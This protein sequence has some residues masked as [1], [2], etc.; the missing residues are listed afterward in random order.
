[1]T[2]RDFA[3]WLKGFFEISKSDELTKE[4]VQEIKTHLAASFV[5]FARAEFIPNN[6]I[7]LCHDGVFL[8]DIKPFTFEGIVQSSSHDNPVLNNTFSTHDARRDTH[9]VVR[10]PEPPASC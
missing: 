10:Y 9:P 1:M 2:H 3:Y 7:Q 5:P 8:R 4:Q 6:S